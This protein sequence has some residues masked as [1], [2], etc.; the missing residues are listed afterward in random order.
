MND[1][2]TIIQSIEDS[3]SAHKSSGLQQNQFIIQSRQHYDAPRRLPERHNQ[4]IDL[5]RSAQRATE[6]MRMCSSPPPSPYLQQLRQGGRDVDMNDENRPTRQ[7]HL[8]DIEHSLPTP[9]SWQRHDPGF[10]PGM[11]TRDEFVQPPRVLVHEDCLPMR[12]DYPVQPSYNHESSRVA[13]N[14]GVPAHRQVVY[15][16]IDDRHQLSRSVR[17]LPEPPASAHN[18]RSDHQYYVLKAPEKRHVQSQQY[19]PDAPSRQIT[20]DTSVPMDGVQHSADPR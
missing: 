13:S 11:R 4:L 17:Y 8:V 5:T 2:G 19:Y 3:D 6:R 1:D 9:V 12:H 15:E 16:P 18:S 7:R 10:Q 14:V 20:L